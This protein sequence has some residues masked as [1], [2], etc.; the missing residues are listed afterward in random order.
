MQSP[1]PQSGWAPQSPAQTLLEQPL[2]LGRYRVVEA[3]GTG[4]FGSVKVC[5]DIRLERRVAI[6]CLPLSQAPETSAST[7]SEA[8]D[9][10]RITSRLT[11]PNIVTVHDFEVENGCAYLIME[12]VNGLTLAELM[13]RVEGGVLT[14]DECAHL[15]DSLADA[16]DYA[17]GQGVLHLDIKPS[18]ILI[19]TTGAVKLGDF[20]MASLA[21]AAGWEGARGGTVGY[22]PPEQL[23]CS[24]V[25]ERTDVFSL[26][27]VLYQALTGTSPFAAKDAEASLKKIVRG[28]KPLTKVEPELAGPVSDGLIRALSAD[29][30]ERP[31]SAGELARAVIPYLG[32]EMEGRQSVASLLSQASGETGPDEQAWDDAARVSLVERWPWLPGAVLRATSALAC[33]GAAARMAPATAPRLAALLPAGALVPVCA[34]ALAA[35]GA[36]LPEAGGI[37]AC[38]LAVVA[39]AA[40]GV[41]SPAFLV[42]GV[43]GLALL[44]WRATTA[45]ASKLAHAAL[46]LPVALT[47]PVGGVALA[48]GTLRP[49]PAALT[50]AAGAALQL[51]LARTLGAATGADV[52]AAAL[53]M[54]VSPVAWLFVAGTAASAW[55]CAIVSADGGTARRCVGQVLG[56]AAAI[57]T[58]ALARRVENGGLWAAPAASDIAVAVVCA[59]LVMIETLTLGPV[60]QPREDD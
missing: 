23:Q 28:A 59:V 26:A 30:G 36:A 3:R 38:V 6:K 8:L 27:V 54:L 19:D 16:L 17:H 22:M 5:W 51:L 31:T 44:G 1:E 46:L 34:L 13:A 18:N 49:K 32:D 42:A 15:L 55:L 39:V 60:C 53:G 56:G 20:G 14:Y 58:L 7:L 43:V 52:A 21:S 24:L 25:D 35:A 11:H 45:G 29:A 33:A 40:P 50:A 12:F 2:L 4:G 10:A 47:S 9:E 48:G 37:L 41:Y 57:A